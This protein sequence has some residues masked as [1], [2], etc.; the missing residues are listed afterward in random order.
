[1]F[2][3]SACD[4]FSGQFTLFIPTDDAF[5]SLADDVKM[6]LSK[7]PDLLRKVLMYHAVD[8]I[9]LSSQLAN[10]I[11]IDSLILDAK[12]RI[13]IYTHPKTVNK[14]KSSSV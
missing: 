8:G 12:I 9:K 7:E 13:N 14:N 10:D 6:L 5:N 4:F 11:E 1:M 3:I 2:T